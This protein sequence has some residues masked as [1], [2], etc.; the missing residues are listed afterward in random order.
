MGE[1]RG[2]PRHGSVEVL[3]AQ[4]WTGE[5]MRVLAT[6]ECVVCTYLYILMELVIS[7]QHIRIPPDD[8]H[9]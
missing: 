1:G 6:T 8:L 3:A 5:T 2:A 4:V 9:S 7:G